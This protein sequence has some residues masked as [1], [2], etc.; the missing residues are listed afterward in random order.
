MIH[1]ADDLR[2]HIARCTTGFLRIVFLFLPGYSEVSD[3]QVAALLEDKVLR[4]EISVN[5]PLRVDILKPKDDATS[6]EF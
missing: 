4:L 1:S 5:D 2:S 3:S 6:D